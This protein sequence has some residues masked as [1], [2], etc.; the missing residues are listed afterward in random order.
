MLNQSHQE[1]SDKH[2]DLRPILRSCLQNKYQSEVEAFRYF[3]LNQSGTISQA[4]FIHMTKS[5][6]P[7][8]QEKNIIKLFR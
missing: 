8:A 1:P 4:E 7:H 6:L 3:D 5:L 2:S